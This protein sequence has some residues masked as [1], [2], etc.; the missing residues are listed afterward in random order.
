MKKSFIIIL[1]AVIGLTATSCSTT[2]QTMREPNVHFELTSNDYVLSDQVTGEATITRVLGIDW[3]RILNQKLGSFE[4]PVMGLNLRL[5]YDSLYAIYDLL[6]KHPGW[7]FVMYP[8][9]ETVSE[10]VT[11]I[12]TNTTVKV[13][14]RL[15]KFKK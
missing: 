5:N 13:T 8:Q 7:D 6:E 10:G 4:A 9:V 11:G 15:G 1:L 2:F 3:M 12:Y 14:A